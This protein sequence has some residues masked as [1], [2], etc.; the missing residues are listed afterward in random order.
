MNP[1]N[2]NPIEDRSNCQAVCDTMYCN[3]SGTANIPYEEATQE[4]D[5]HN[6]SYMGHETIIVCG[7]GNNIN[8][9]IETE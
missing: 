7:R 8:D 2:L 9:S 5:D 3:W 6:T 4:A 1:D